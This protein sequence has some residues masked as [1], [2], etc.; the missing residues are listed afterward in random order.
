MC[1]VSHIE[2]F[3]LEFLKSKNRMCHIGHMVE[4]RY[5]DSHLPNWIHAVEG[6]H[7]VERMVEVRFFVFVGDVECHFC[8]M[9]EI[10]FF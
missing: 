10:L 1:D 5:P 4:F 6:L 9:F 7:L 3:F 2:I 8:A